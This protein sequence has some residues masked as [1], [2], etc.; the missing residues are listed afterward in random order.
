MIEASGAIRLHLK[1]QSLRDI[2]KGVTL[3]SVFSI[4]IADKRGKIVREF[5]ERKFVGLDTFINTGYRD[6]EKE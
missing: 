6:K 3:P 4:V 5:P 1:P 2:L